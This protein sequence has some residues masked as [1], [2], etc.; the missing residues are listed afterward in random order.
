MNNGDTLPYKAKSTALE[1]KVKLHKFLP[2]GRVV[3]TVV[4]RGGEHWIDTS[5][6]FCSCRAFYFE[7]TSGK[8]PTCYHLK[9][10]QF[11]HDYNL[12]DII[13]FADEEFYGFMYGLVSDV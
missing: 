9:S 12:I 6:N 7:M 13:E 3:M 1:K 8:N 10:A 4:G 2:S 5:L 11:A